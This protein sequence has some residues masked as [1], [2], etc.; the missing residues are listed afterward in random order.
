MS[1]L[2][3]YLLFFSTLFSQ[4][5]QQVKDLQSEY[6]KLKRQNQSVVQPGANNLINE[7]DFA[8]ARTDLIPNIPIDTEIKEKG[9]YF[10]G[11]DFFLKRDTVSFWENH[12]HKVAFIEQ[13]P[14]DILC[15]A[16][17]MDG[18]IILK[19]KQQDG[20][21]LA[22]TKRRVAFGKIKSSIIYFNP[23]S[24]RLE[25]VIEHELG[26]AFGYKHIDEV[27]HVMHPEWGKMGP[28]FWLP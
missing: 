16:E 27:G 6:D 9:S 13:N 11:Y 4:S 15:E 26:H 10:F 19:M 2:V 24:Y 28:N 18:W 23:G 1:K 7:L 25:N 8:P 5:L 3:I 17:S 22:V 20:E 14:P 21:T 12:G